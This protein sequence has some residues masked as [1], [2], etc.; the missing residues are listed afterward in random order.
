MLCCNHKKRWQPNLIHMN[1]R[2]GTCE[3]P[4]FGPAPSAV[5]RWVS[6][7]ASQV[8]PHAPGVQGTSRAA[9][10]RGARW[11]VGPQREAPG[12]PDP[13]PSRALCCFNRISISINGKQSPSLIKRLRVA[14]CVLLRGALLAGA[15]PQWSKILLSCP[16]EI[17][18]LSDS[19]A[20]ILVH[21]TRSTVWKPNHLYIIKETV[22]YRSAQ[23]PPIYSKP[24]HTKTH[25]HRRTTGH[26]S[27]SHTHATH[28][29][30]QTPTRITRGRAR[31]RTCTDTATRTHANSGRVPHASS[32][33]TAGKFRR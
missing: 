2:E 22:I 3:T 23:R 20:S 9:A 29:R 27:Q 5:A 18:F 8:R 30:T 4:T 28:T 6:C 12:S 1:S 31:T 10:P 32:T 26:D 7:K 21:T 11:Q 19:E 17:R 24:M 15:G 16:F 14:R 33:A 25:S 13:P